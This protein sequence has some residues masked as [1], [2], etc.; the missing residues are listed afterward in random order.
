[1]S[2][3]KS[4]RSYDDVKEIFDAALAQGGCRVKCKQ[5]VNLRARLNHFRAL[6]RDS[7]AQIYPAGHPRHGISIYDPFVI[8]VVGEY[9]VL[10]PRQIG[11][12]TIE[13]LPDPVV[14]QSDPERLGLLEDIGPNESHPDLIESSTTEK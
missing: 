5:L 4:L 13:P 11:G 2:F 14:I 6:D 1:M 9:L 7:M 12:Y 8:R 3:P 10:E